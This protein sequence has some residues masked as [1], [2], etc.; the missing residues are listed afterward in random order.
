[1]KFRI[2]VFYCLL[3]QIISNQILA[4]EIPFLRVGYLPNYRFHL[5]DS[6][7]FDK[8][9]HLCIAFGNPTSKGSLSFNG[10]DIGPVVAKAKA[11]EIKILLSLGGGLESHKVKAWDKWLL[12]WNRSAFIHEIMEWVRQYQFDGVDVDLEWNN[13]KPTYEPF[14]TELRDSIDAANKL[15]TVALPGIKRYKHLT[16]KALNVFDYIFLMSYDLTGPW[17]PRQAGQH[18]P[19]SMAVESINFWMGH[20]VEPERLVLGLPF[21]GW[22]FTNPRK[23]YSASYG[24][25][26]TRDS[27]L[28]ELDRFG[29]VFYN[30][31]PLIE[32]KTEYALEKVGGVMFWEIG[33]DAFNDLSLVK[34]V[35]RVVHDY[36]NSYLNQ[37]NQVDQISTYEVVSINR[38]PLTQDYIFS[39]NPKAQIIFTSIKNSTTTNVDIPN[40][41]TGVYILE[42]LIKQKFWLSGLLKRK[43]NR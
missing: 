21:Y 3:L 43:E 10:Q 16:N 31:R 20:G 23:T 12:P 28:I 32:A 6:L 27:S 26:A 37:D 11:S 35:D 42:H 40:Y 34:A 41:P 25:L 38:K 9:T 33:Q 17:A 8:L 19:F 14:V 1:M 2:A 22:D 30:G 13:V 5:I 4:Q 39:T 36:Y 24:F 18:A 7:E 15:L 29:D